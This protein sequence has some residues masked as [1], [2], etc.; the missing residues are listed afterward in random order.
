MSPYLDNTFFKQNLNAVYHINT[1]IND[2]YSYNKELAAEFK[3]NLVFQIQ[4]NRKISGQEA[5]DIATEQVYFYLDIF[6]KSSQELIEKFS[7]NKKM[8]KY[9]KYLK[10]AIKATQVWSVYC[11]RYSMHNNNLHY[12]K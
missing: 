2:I 8:T 9:I 10:Y 5:M 7:S 11:P 12:D 4:E 1:I 6:E 3:S